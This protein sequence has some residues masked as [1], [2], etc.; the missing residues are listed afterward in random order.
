[1]FA[2]P[3]F[4]PNLEDPTLSYG[5]MATKFLPAGLLGLVLASMFANTLSMTSSDSN[6]VSAVITRDILPNVF[7]RIK[8][9]SPKQSLLLA[10]ITTFLFTLLT[11][12]IAL[13][14]SHFGGVFGLIVSW[15]AAL[16]G[17]IAI[18]MILGLLPF[19]KRSGSSS[20]ILSIVGGL[21]VFVVT[22]VVGFS[23]TVEVS[24]PLLT[25]LILFVLSGFLMED[26][27]DERNRLLDAL[28]AKEK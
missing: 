15:F 1:M 27:S 11:I 28:N 5:M 20:A 6:T 4:F 21:L 17:P 26:T 24:A 14:S 3:V 13:N 2:A 18:P 7:Q 8:T 23:L 25:S 16:L 19:F 10:R 12:I 22:K 9:F